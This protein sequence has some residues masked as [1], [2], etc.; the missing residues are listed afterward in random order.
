LLFWCSNQQIAKFQLFSAF[1]AEKL[2]KKSQN[3]KIMM[4]R[5]SNSVF[6]G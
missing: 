4:M 3:N 5:K 6:I 1:K 2:N